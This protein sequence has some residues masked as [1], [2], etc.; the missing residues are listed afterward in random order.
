MRLP[1]PVLRAVAFEIALYWGRF[2]L[3]APL[4]LPYTQRDNDFTQRFHSVEK[5]SLFT[6]CAPRAPAVDCLRMFPFR[7]VLASVLRRGRQPGQ[8]HAES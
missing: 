3:P 6:P 2:R 5:N 4:A 1:C 8:R 7:A